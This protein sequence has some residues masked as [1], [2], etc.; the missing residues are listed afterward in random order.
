MSS[1][2]ACILRLRVIPLGVWSEATT[3]VQ[4]PASEGEVPKDKLTSGFVGHRSA[5]FDSRA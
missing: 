2:L 3:F 4:R 1:H 5:M